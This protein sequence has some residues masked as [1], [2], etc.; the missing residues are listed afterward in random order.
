[1]DEAI[2]NYI[3]KNFNLAIGERTTIIC[4]S[5]ET[6]LGRPRSKEPPPAI[7]MPRSII[8]TSIFWITVIVS[9]S[10]KAILGWRV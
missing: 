9:D 4:V 5:I 3:K 6:S 2:V 7:T 1:M 10:F 8:S